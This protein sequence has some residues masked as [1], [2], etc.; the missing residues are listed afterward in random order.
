[1][2]LSEATLVWNPGT[3]HV[4]MLWHPIGPKMSD[5]FECSFGAGDA[6]WE[7]QSESERVVAMLATAIDAIALDGV[8]AQAMRAVLMSVDEL[9]GMFDPGVEA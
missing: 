8:D 9:R 1:M 4:G 3:S 7:Q 5:A 2:K 6:T